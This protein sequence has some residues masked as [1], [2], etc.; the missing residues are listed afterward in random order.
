MPGGG[1][2]QDRAGSLLSTFAM[3]W[4][5][6]R[7]TRFQARQPDVELLIPT[8]I[9]PVDLSREAFDCVIRFGAGAWPGVLADGS[10]ARS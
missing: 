8:S 5:I 7:L 2:V 3:R 9:R 1:A 4:L 10:T 6:P